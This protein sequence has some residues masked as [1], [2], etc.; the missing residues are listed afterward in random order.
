MKIIRVLPNNR[1]RSFL[2]ECG[3]GML[4]FPFSCLDLIPSQEDPVVEVFVDS[5]LADRG[6]TYRLQSGKEASIMLDQVLYQNQDG[7]FIRELTLH[8]LT[9]KALRIVEQ[10]RIP[11]RQLARRLKTSPRQLYRLLDT[12]FYGKTIDQMLK[13]LTALGYNVEFNLKKRKAA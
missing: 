5:E 8:N 11:K 1:K 13:L 2:V 12:A 9:V 4:E 6:F 10:E 3:K 7:D